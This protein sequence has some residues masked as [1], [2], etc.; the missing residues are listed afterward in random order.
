M[1]ARTGEEFIAGLRAQRREV[2]IQGE[3]VADVA[4]HPAF[5]NVVRSTQSGGMG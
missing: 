1:P 3:R 2:W 4:A 5:R